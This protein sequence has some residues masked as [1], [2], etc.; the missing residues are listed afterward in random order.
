MRKQKCTRRDKCHLAGIRAARLTPE[1]AA[2]AW[3]YLAGLLDDMGTIDVP[4]F[5][6]LFSA[7]RESTIK[8]HG[9]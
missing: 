4:K 3:A 6:H 5:K 1:Q 9:R 7:I 2:R 8:G